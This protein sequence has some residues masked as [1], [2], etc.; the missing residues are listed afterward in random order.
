MFVGSAVVARLV[1]DGAMDQ[2]R[3]VLERSDPSWRAVDSVD[4]Q[5][6]LCFTWRLGRGGRIWC[7]CCWSLIRM[8]GQWGSVG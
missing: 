8:W 7:S 2:I 5:G 1:A 4:E 3:E 6:G